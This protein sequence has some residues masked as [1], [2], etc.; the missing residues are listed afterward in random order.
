M[1]LIDILAP[2]IVYCLLLP[3]L[4]VDCGDDLLDDAGVRKL[5]AGMTHQY[6]SMPVQGS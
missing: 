6:R 1:S 5:E 2:A 4:L 3:S